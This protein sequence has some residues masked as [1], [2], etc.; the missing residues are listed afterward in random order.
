MKC[1]ANKK[2]VCCK[3]GMDLRYEYTVNQNR[4]FHSEIARVNQNREFHS[5][6]AREKH[7]LFC[8]ILY[9]I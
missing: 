6:I 5:E 3:E 8:I 7:D 1:Q 2:E 9:V 4:E